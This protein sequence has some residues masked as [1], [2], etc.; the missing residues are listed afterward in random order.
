MF[1]TYHKPTERHAKRIHLK[2]AYKRVFTGCRVE[3][4]LKSQTQEKPSITKTSGDSAAMGPL[5]NEVER[6][7]Q[8]TVRPVQEVNLWVHS[9]IH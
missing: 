2:M 8:V 3:C 6:N 1:D 5:E 7:D 9:K 4:E